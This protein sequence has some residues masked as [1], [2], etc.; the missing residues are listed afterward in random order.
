LFC[1]VGTFYGRSDWLAQF[2]I[3]SG[4]LSNPMVFEKP[5][6]HNFSIA[7]DLPSNPMV[8]E[9]PDWHKSYIHF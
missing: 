4:F 7:L 1:V 5:N 9:M 3:A 6:L 2:S 8:L